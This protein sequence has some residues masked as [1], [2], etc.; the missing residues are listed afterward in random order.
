MNM[1]LKSYDGSL[2]TPI[3]SSGDSQQEWLDF[4]SDSKPNQEEV[5]SRN[6]V[7]SQR[8]RMFNQALGCLGPREKDI[9]FKRRLNEKQL[10]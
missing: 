4:I 1:R 6:Q 5:F 2:N 8:R 9:L 7:M 3:D 10:L